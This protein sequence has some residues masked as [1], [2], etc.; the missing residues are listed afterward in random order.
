MDVPNFWTPH[1]AWTYMDEDQGRGSANWVEKEKERCTNYTF[2][3]ETTNVAFY[4]HYVTLH[5]DLTGRTFSL[6]FDGI[7]KD[8][9]VWVNGLP[10]GVHSGLFTTSKFDVTHLVKPGENMITVKAGDFTSFDILDP[11][12][13]GVV[14]RVPIEKKLGA[15]YPNGMLFS[16]NLGIWQ[17]VS[18]TVSGGINIDDTFFRPDLNS[19]ALNVKVS[20]KKFFPQQFSVASQIRSY[21]DNSIIYDSFMSSRVKD[22]TIDAGIQYD[23]IILEDS[24]EHEQFRNWSPEFPHL[25]KV[26]TFTYRYNQRLN[27]SLAEFAAP[28]LKL[29]F[30]PYETATPIGWTAAGADVYNPSR[31][32]GWNVQQETRKRG[33]LTD[34]LLD[35]LVRINRGSEATFTCDVPNGDYVLS[36]QF[37][38]PAFPTLAEAYIGNDTSDINKVIVRDAVDMNTPVIALKSLSIEDGKLQITIPSMPSPAI[39]TSLNWLV[40]EPR[41]AVSIA[42]WVSG[43]STCDPYQNSIAGLLSKLTRLFSFLFSSLY[44][45]SRNLV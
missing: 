27:V 29:N 44:L 4:R 25:Y 2:D 30:Q 14:E 11:S 24:G 13:P 45:K 8:G 10:A 5:G 23:G 35:S 38:D 37:A 34:H 43:E 28:V 3:Y 19:Y 21:A 17:G 39:G 40:L 7:G 20:N 9:E 36:L 15:S 12:V 32:F 16:R 6:T 1:Y 18:I 26:D 33:L 31:G 22:V 42:K 41:A